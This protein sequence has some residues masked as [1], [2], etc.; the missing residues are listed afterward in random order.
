MKNGKSLNH[1]FRPSKAEDVLLITGGE[2]LSMPSSMS[3]ALVANGAS[4][5]MIFRRGRLSTPIFATGGWT[6]LGNVF[7]IVCAARCAGPLAV[8]LNPARLS[9]IVRRSRRPKKGAARLRCGEEDK[10]PKTPY[11]GRYAGLGAGSKS[12]RRLGSRPRWRQD[13]L[14]AARGQAL[15]LEE[16]L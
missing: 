7:T 4:C 14:E 13:C 3:C 10:G 11:F 9:W 15:A 5:R 2:R 8:I 12:P 1:W 6:A 16:D